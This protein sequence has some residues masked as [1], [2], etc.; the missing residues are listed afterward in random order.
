[1]Y[2]HVLEHKNINAFVTH[3]GLLSTQESIFYGVPMVAISLFGDQFFNA[4]TYT[5]KNVAVKVDLDEITEETFTKALYTVL[6]DP[7]IR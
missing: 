1:M 2:Y 3:G 6:Y 7:S 5:K 4:D